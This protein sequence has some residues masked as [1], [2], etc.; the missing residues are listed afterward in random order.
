M[1]KQEYFELGDAFAFERLTIDN[2]ANGVACTAATFAPS[3]N[4]AAS[5]ARM[6]C[7]TQ[8]ISYREDGTAPVAAQAI[9]RAVGD[10]WL[11]WGINNIKNFKAIRNNAA[12]GYIAVTYYR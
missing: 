11:V 6:V 4:R 1:L 2:N 10:E 9:Q 5:C 12:N 7:D 3:G 8:P